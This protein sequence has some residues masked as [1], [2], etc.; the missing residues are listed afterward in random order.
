MFDLVK[1]ALI[2][3]VFSAVCLSTTIASAALVFEFSESGGDMTVSYSGSLDFT[4]MS[5][6]SLT[7]GTDSGTTIF[8]LGGLNGI[9][10]NTGV[11]TRDYGAPFSSPTDFTIASTSPWPID[12]GV[13]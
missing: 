7:V 11:P 13:A 10:F 12:C 2:G 3:G 9:R 4:G 6:A 5:F 8:S 1:K